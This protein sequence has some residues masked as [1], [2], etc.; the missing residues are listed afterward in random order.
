MADIEKSV[1]EIIDDLKNKINELS[2]AGEDADDSAIQKINEIKQ[3]AI[4]VLNQAS[5]K[6]IETAKDFSDSEEVQ[7]GIEI[8]KVKSKELY[9]NAMSRINELSSSNKVEQVKGDVQEVIEEIKEN[10]ETFLEKE[11]VKEVVDTVKDKTNNIA[12]KAINTLKEWL[13]PEDK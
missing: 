3:K 5:N 4:G 7:K 1:N 10:V 11:E 12:D 13:K 6:V 8:V 9:D 2:K